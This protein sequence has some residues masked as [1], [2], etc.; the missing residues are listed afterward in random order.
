MEYPDLAQITSYAQLKQLRD[1]GGLTPAEETLLD[2]ARIGAVTA[3]REK[4]PKAPDP[5]VMIRASL[6]RFVVLG[7]CPEWPTDV[8][9]IS[10]RG[11]W[12]R[13]DLNLSFGEGVGRLHLRDCQFEGALVTRQFHVAAV[14]LNRSRF[15][16]GVDLH[17]SQIAGDML[18]REVAVEG[19][20]NL[21][22]ARAGGQV[23][24]DGAT[25]LNP[26]ADALNAQGL[27]VGKA[28]F[29]RELAGIDG[30]VRLTGARFNSLADDA[31]SWAMTP[32]LMFDGLQFERLSG[33]TDM[34]MRL[35]WLERG[36]V[37]D[38]E[39]RPHPYAHFADVMRE[40][41][42]T[43]EARRVMM[44]K[45]RLQRAFARRRWR[46]EGGQGHKVAGSLI[47]DHTQ[48]WLV[49]YGYQPLRSVAALL[50][51]ILIGAF[52]AHQAWEAGDFAPN[53]APVLMSPGWQAV[54]VG[55]DQMAN[56]AEVWSGP[57]Q[58]GRDYE[59]FEA[60]YYGVDLVI[61]L[62]Q[63]GQE[64]AWAPSTTRGPWGWWLWWIRWWLIAMGWIVTAIG[65]AAVTGII[66]KE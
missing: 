48:R 54:S 51:L 42:H 43:A 56:P 30:M 32:D 40:T 57:D 12:I 44:E 2:M 64:K 18:F 60:F 65:A 1:D 34:E 5:E 33:P 45:E 22:S 36:A 19:G 20:L 61:P 25:L 7:G 41:G 63:L 11:A 52:L 58:A 24:F 17:G 29:W 3:L 14:V 46:S 37:V 38:D 23:D 59:T 10:I 50:V 15:P 55:P 35:P 31:E 8:Q 53:A 21:M 62:V 47:A 16:K 9:G 13:Q 28:F 39:F 4:V 26:G 66:R 27:V 6:L 49:G